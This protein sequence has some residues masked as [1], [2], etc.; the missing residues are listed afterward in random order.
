MG[1][2]TAIMGLIAI[3]VLEAI[4]L[5]IALITANRR[6]AANTDNNADNNA[7]A[8]AHL[9]ERLTEL[10]QRLNSTQAESSGVLNRQI[11]R[12]DTKI[13]AVDNNMQQLQRLFRNVKLRGAW[14]EAQLAAILS[15]LLTPAQYDTNVAIDPESAERVEFALKLPLPDNTYMW[16]P[17]DAKCPIEDFE[18]WQQAAELGDRDLAEKY[19]RALGRRLLEESADVAQKYIR[20]PYSTDFALLFLPIE[21]IYQWAI[22]QPALIQDME[23]KWRVIPCS[24]S[25]ITAVLNLVQVAHRSMAI[26]Q[27]ENEVW[28]YLGNI[29]QEVANFDGAITKS[30]KKTAELTNS[31]DELARR[32][33]ALDRRLTELEAL[34]EKPLD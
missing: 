28:R 25:T 16:L 3:I 24:P 32:L 19:G 5:V 10:E 13:G 33:R 30:R 20:P 31:L 12:L 9:L 22:N 2:Q 27:R 17:I 26:S 34:E 4:V 11:S 8:Y 14:G 18:R 29:K 15:E 23:R 6:T 1:E 7:E 21:G